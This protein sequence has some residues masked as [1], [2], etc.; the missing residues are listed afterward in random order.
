VADNNAALGQQVLDVTEAEVEAEVQP[1]S[2]GDHFGREA[3]ATVERRRICAAVGHRT[4]LPTQLD[5][6]G[7]CTHDWRDRL[8]E[9]P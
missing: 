2:M 6:A 7:C 5:N 9:Q 1:D 4:S 8:D 3:M